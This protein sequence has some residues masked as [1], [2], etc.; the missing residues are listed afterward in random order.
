MIPGR[1]RG[2]ASFASRRGSVAGTA[3]SVC[4]VGIRGKYRDIHLGE[5]RANAHPVEGDRFT[6]AETIELERP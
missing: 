3:A 5:R 2:G 1:I 6:L 4:F